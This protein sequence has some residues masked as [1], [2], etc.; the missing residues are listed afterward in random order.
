VLRFFDRKIS[1]HEIAQIAQ[2]TSAIAMT[3]TIGSA[4]C[5]L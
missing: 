2:A 4:G 1:A 3:V 5:L